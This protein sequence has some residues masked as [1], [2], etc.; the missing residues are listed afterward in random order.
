MMELGIS[1]FVELTPDPT[2]GNTI[3]PYQR[4]QNLMEEVVLA[5]QLGLDVFAIGEHH[6][7]D[8]LVSSPA[9]VLSAAAVKTKK[10]QTFQRSKRIKF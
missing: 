1:T 2:T 9:T 6:R 8:F 5:D 7:P 10:Y 3:T 4:F